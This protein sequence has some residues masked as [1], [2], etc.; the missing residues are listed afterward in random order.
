[1]WRSAL[2]GQAAGSQCS[3]AVDQFGTHQIVRLAAAEISS[4]EYNQV[5][6]LVAIARFLTAQVKSD[7]GIPTPRQLDLTKA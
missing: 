4:S 1:M 5:K 6:A 7:I 2:F 3:N